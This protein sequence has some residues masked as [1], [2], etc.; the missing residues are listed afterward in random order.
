M[1]Y[2]GWVVLGN[3]DRGKIGGTETKKTLIQT[4][5]LFSSSFEVKASQRASLFMPARVAGL[6]GVLLRGWGRGW[7]Y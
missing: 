3:I 1:Q 6:L 2:L 4:S 5:G 7:G